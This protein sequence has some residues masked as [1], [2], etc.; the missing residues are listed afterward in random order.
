MTYQTFGTNQTGSSGGASSSATEDSSQNQIELQT[1][2]SRT[3][4]LARLEKPK[5]GIQQEN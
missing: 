3:E 5:P 2:F 4:G 1:L